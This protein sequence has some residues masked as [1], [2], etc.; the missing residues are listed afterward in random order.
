MN[1]GGS[2]RL[3]REGAALVE[4]AQDVVNTIFPEQTVIRRRK[5]TGQGKKSSVK[6]TRLEN[7]DTV[8]HH[9]EGADSLSID[10]LVVL[11]G[12]K[13]A[14]VLERV[15]RLEIQDKLEEL[16]GHRYRIKK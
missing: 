6:E 13:T 1:F 12:E 8:L 10:E 15:A 4:N 11:T 14:D 3:I 2:N 9:F 7:C 16:P 5:I